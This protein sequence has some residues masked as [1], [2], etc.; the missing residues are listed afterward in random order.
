MQVRNGLF[1]HVVSLF[2]DQTGL[3]LTI[4]RYIRAETECYWTETECM[5][6][7]MPYLEKNGLF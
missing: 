7:K 2:F 6:V 5:H 1:G 3:F 4:S